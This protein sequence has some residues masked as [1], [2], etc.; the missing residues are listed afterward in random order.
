[1]RFEA[2]TLAGGVGYIAFNL[3]FDPEFVLG[4]FETAL[5]AYIADDAPGVILDLRGNP[6][7]LGAMA[8]GVAGWFVERGEQSLGTMRSRNTKITFAIFPR[9]TPYA[10]PVAILV[11]GCTA[12]TAEILAGG[13]QDLGRARIFGTRTAGAALPSAIETLP[14][15]DG[16][17]YA[18]A[19]YVSTGGRRL[20]GQGV[21]PD[22]E[23]EPTRAQLLAGRDP[24]LEAARAWIAGTPDGG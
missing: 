4:Q 13:L 9:A 21:V 7:G 17:Q 3:F 15:G 8:M 2:R 23:F 14:N 18:L 16:F 11:D 22:V 24:V 12:S 6:G 20:E 10:G 19:D 1:V 5:R